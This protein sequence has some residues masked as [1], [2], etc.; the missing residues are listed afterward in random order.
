MSDI[1]ICVLVDDHGVRRCRVLGWISSWEPLQQTIAFDHA[2][3]LV[4]MGEKVWVD[5]RSAPAAFDNPKDRAVDWKSIAQAAKS[6]DRPPLQMEGSWEP[7]V[8]E[9]PFEWWEPPIAAIGL[10][11]A[12][13]VDG[14]DQ[15]C[16]RCGG[17]LASTRIEGMD[18]PMLRNPSVVPQTRYPP[19]CIVERG[20]GWQALALSPTAVPS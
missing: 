1:N 8:G 17:L 10:H 3:T 2:K 6:G 4:R 20:R 16:S 15:Y 19:G 13:P 12:G 14:T 11:L 9:N 7:N 5:R 18:G